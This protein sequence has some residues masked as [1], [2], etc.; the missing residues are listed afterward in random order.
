MASF[1]IPRRFFERAM[2]SRDNRHA[3]QRVW[4]SNSRVLVKYICDTFDS[5]AFVCDLSL[6][7]AR[8]TAR[9]DVVGW[10]RDVV[11]HCILRIP[12]DGHDM[13]RAFSDFVVDGNAFDSVLGGKLLRVDLA[14]LD[15]NLDS[16]N[17]LD[18]SW[19]YRIVSRDGY[20]W[21]DDDRGK[22]RLCS[23]QPYSTP[24]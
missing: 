12:I 6:R 24:H 9:R 10:K 20:V 1:E 3:S 18:G 2:A 19:R 4:S 22:H 5:I 15:K 17:S 23:P 7:W 14:T 16:L 13:D 11:F 21:L 8:E